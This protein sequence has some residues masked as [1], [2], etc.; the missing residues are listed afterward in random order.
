MQPTSPRSMVFPDPLGPLRTVTSRERI[1]TDTPPRAVN[2]LCLP[3]LEV[4]AGGAAGENGRIEGAGEPC[5]ASAYAAILKVL[6]IVCN[7]S[8]SRD[9]SLAAAAES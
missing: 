3:A 5:P 8:A 4:G 7:S 9:S 1:T 6:T 2:S